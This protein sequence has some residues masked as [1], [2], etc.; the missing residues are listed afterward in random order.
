MET[1]PRLLQNK[2]EA[3][4]FLTWVATLE[5]GIFPKATGRLQ[6]EDGYCCLGVACILFIPEKRLDISLESNSRELDGCT[7]FAQPHSP[8]WLKNV[9]NNFLVRTGISLI[10]HNDGHC[11]PEKPHPKIAKM[12]LKEYK[13]ELNELLS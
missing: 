6:N 3:T 9:N 13:E 8:E 1:K 4:Q 10:S 2:K 11:T 5:A 12:L 7:P